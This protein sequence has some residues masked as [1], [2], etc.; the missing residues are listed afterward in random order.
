MRCI[1][2]LTKVQNCSRLQPPLGGQHDRFETRASRPPGSHTKDAKE[3]RQPKNRLHIA[4]ALLRSHAD[5]LMEI[6]A[7]RESIPGPV[8]ITLQAD[9]HS[10]FRMCEAAPAHLRVVECLEDF[11]VER[12]GAGV[13]ARAYGQPVKKSPSSEFHIPFHGYRS[14]THTRLNSSTRTTIEMVDIAH[15]LRVSSV[16]G[17][18]ASVPP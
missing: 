3:P 4:G 5:C 13:V 18:G 16:G 11:Q 7:S 17:A 8:G 12:N 9:V 1:C 15:I 6:S 2:S 14:R 10:S